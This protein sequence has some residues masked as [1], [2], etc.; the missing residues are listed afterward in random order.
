MQQLQPQNRRVRVPACASWGRR[1]SRRRVRVASLAIGLG[2][3]AAC[4]RDDVAGVGRPDV[5]EVT[6]ARLSLAVG[7][8]APV[9]VR[10][11]A[12]EGPA[13][14]GAIGF[15]AA[16]APSAAVLSVRGTS[17]TTAVVRATGV[18]TGSVMLRAPQG[19][20]FY[21]VQVDVRAR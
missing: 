15:S 14:A 12:G 3:L 20:S 11:R 13:R 17:D 4:G 2:V 19:S 21:F 9:V 1:L 6:P 5:W 10:F 7:D 18:G 8:S 16:A